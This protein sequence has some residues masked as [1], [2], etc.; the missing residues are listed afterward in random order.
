[1]TIF[2]SD[3]E[4][5]IWVGSDN[6]H[7]LLLTLRGILNNKRIKHTLTF[8]NSCLSQCFPCVSIYYLQILIVA[9]ENIESKA[10]ILIFDNFSV[11]PQDNYRVSVTVDGTEVPDS[12]ICNGNPWHNN[13]LLRVRKLIIYI[14]CNLIVYKSH[15]VYNLNEWVTLDSLYLLL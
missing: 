8:R 2:F 3:H 15:S 13:C 14:L 6:S 7:V 1:M 9:I 11:L 5:I 10:L 12:G 4:E